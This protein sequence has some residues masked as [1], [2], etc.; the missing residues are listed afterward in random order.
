MDVRLNIFKEGTGKKKKVSS[1]ELGE[2]RKCVQG[3][4][5]GMGGSMLRRHRKKVGGGNLGAR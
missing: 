2:D 4:G 3:P 5:P 1:Y